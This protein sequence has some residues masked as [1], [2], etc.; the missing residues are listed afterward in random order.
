MTRK[1]SKGSSTSTLR[2]MSNLTSIADSLLEITDSE[3]EVK[4]I[5]A[6]V[7]FLYSNPDSTLTARS[8]AGMFKGDISEGGC[9][10]LIFAMEQADVLNSED[11]NRER[12]QAAAGAAKT[13]IS[14]GGDL[15]NDVVVTVP[16]E[17]DHD[18]G[19]SLGSLVVRLVE[20]L[21]GAD[22]EIVIL[23]PFFTTQAFG[24]IVGPLSGALERGVS[25]TLI[26]RYLTYGR[27]E[28]SR[29]FVR[30]L[31][32][33]DSPPKGLTLYEYIDP[34]D[35]SSATIHAKM[36]IVDRNRAY[37]GTA[38]LTHRGL[39]ENLEIGVIFQDATV[40]QLTRFT[41]DLRESGYLHEIEYQDGAFDRV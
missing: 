9:R 6:A 7:E 21:A 2:K 16:Q 17:D 19:Q 35:D 20:L 1:I 8:L 31:F 25:V 10:S 23:N 11:L 41:D 22:E 36:T 30:K 13:I 33:G 40:D 5:V 24:N 12:L 4:A 34:D 26:T 32:D 29:D 39:H 37:L 15:E 18:I 28:D 27:D 38:N 3:R 14:R